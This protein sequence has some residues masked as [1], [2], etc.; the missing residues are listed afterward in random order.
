MA[1][2]SNST[3]PAGNQ[4]KSNASRVGADNPASDKATDPKAAPAAKTPATPAGADL[5]AVCDEAARLL[6]G[7]PDAF[8][9]MSKLVRTLKT[10]SVRAGFEAIAPSSPKTKYVLAQ[11]I[12]KEAGVEDW[13]CPAL[14]ELY[15]RE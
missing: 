1:C 10:S 2:T 9:E 7:S 13:E 4:D 8:A 15:A 6:K 11:E 12:A 14:K 3:A 5:K